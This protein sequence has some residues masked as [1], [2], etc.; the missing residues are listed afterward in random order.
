MV[1]NPKTKQILLINTPRDAYVAN[2]EGDGAMDKLTHCGLYGPDCSA[3]ALSTL[4]GTPIDYFG[5]INFSGFKKLIDAIGGITVYSDQ[6]FT[7]FNGHSIKKGENTFNGEQALAFARERYNV[8]GGD[9]GRGKNQMKVITAVIKKLIS[10]PALITNYA[11]IMASMQ[12]MFTTNMQADEISMLVKMQLNDLATWEINSFSVTG[13]AGSELTYSWAGVK[14]YVL[15]LN[16]NHVTH[17]S[18]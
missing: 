9:N 12:G 14:S 6:A 13:K 15:H 1:V 16:Q 10:S 3:G 7:T 11:S 4:Y 2:P 18:N 8:V 17:A 5:Q